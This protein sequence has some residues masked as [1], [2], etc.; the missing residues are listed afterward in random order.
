[1]L[2]G[3]RGCTD[4]LYSNQKW[5]DDHH[6]RD[7]TCA[8]HPGCPIAAFLQ[9]AMARRSNHASNNCGADTAHPMPATGPHLAAEAPQYPI[10]GRPAER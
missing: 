5:E 4:S 9:C 8:K 10:L 7:L 2:V 3:R 1:M 6:P